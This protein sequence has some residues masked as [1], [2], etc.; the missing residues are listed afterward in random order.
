MLHRQLLRL[1]CLKVFVTIEVNFIQRA[2]GSKFYKYFHAY[3]ENCV[4]EL[5]YLIQMFEFF[6]PLQLDNQKKLLK[7]Y[8]FKFSTPFHIL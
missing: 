5:N 7:K 8:L 3:S 6:S 4:K 1:N 2:F